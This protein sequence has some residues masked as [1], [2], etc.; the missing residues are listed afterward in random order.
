M[1]PRSEST[2][3]KS[4]KVREAAA[5]AESYYPMGAMRAFFLHTYSTL[6]S[7]PWDRIVPT[8]EMDKVWGELELKDAKKR[9][10]YDDDFISYITEENKGRVTL[11]TGEHGSGKTSLLLRICYL[12]A[13]EE[14]RMA[15]YR[16]VLGI[17]LS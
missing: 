11:L 1:E 7:L 4:T 10:T 2:K 17:S 9:I 6:N 5:K 13:K 16:L 14:K 15:R 3:T 8:R 12:W